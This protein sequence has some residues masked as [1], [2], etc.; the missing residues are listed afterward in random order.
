MSEGERCVCVL[1]PSFKKG[2]F[3]NI[4]FRRN[5]ADAAELLAV[6]GGGFEPEGVALVRQAAK[7]SRISAER[8]IKKHLLFFRWVTEHI[9]SAPSRSRRKQGRPGQGGMTAVIQ[10]FILAKVVGMGRYRL[11]DRGLL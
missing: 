5:S 3:L 1:W 7:G 9:H 10:A 4:P 8:N 11:D 6:L 2:V